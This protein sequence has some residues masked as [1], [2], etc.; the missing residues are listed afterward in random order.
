MALS[1]GFIT[2]IQ[3]LLENGALVNDQDTHGDTALHQAAR[4]DKASCVK[5]L[6]SHPGIDIN[7]RNNEGHTAMMVAK[8]T[9]LGV[10][11]QVVKTCSDFPADS[12]GKVVLCGNSG[13]GKS[14][15]TQR[16]FGLRDEI[17]VEPLTAG[18][19]PHQVD[20]PYS[21]MIIYDLAGHHQYFSSHSA[22][23]E[24]I[25]LTSPAIFLLLQDLRHDPEV[26]TK[27]VYYWSTMIDGVCH[28]CPQQSSVIVMGTHADLLPPGQL[29][30]KFTH[31]RSLAKMA[32]SHQKFVNVLALNAAD[33]YSE[34]M[35]QFIDQLC[36][37]N[38]RVLSMS[39]PISMMCH[40]MLAFLK[41]KIPDPD[42]NAI[43][44]SDL[45]G[46]LKADQDKLIQPFSTEIVPIL[47]TLSEKGLI[48]FIPSEDPLNSWIVLHKESILRKVNGALFADPSLKEYIRVAS[49]TGIV[50]K[51]VIKKIFPEY[52][53]E[54]ITQFMIHFELCQVVELSQIE[55]NMAP[56]GSPSSD[57][58]P[59]LFFPA[60]VSVERPSSATVPNNSFR[61]SMIVKCT[62]QFFT[63]RCLH[64]LLHRLPSEFALPPIQVTPL[65]SDLHRKCALWSRGVMWLSETG[66]T[67]IVKMSETF[68]SLSLAMSSPDRE[69]D[70][71]VNL[72]HSVLAIIKTAC[73][74]FC[75]HLE[76]VELIS[77]PPEA[78]LDHSVDRKVKLSSLKNALLKGHK[79]IADVNGE[80]YVVMEKWMK[81]E[82]CLP[83][84]VGVYPSV[85]PF[86][87]SSLP[88]SDLKVPSSQL[89]SVLITQVVVKLEGTPT[90]LELLSFSDMRVNI[91]EQIG[92][93]YLKFGIFLLGDSNGAI[94]TALENEH[95]KN[96]ERINV[97][98][99]QKWLEGKGVKP[100][101]WSTLLTALQKMN[102]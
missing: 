56:E 57:L 74:E 40:L 18:I 4:E 7:I 80:K 77:C 26:M 99:L 9:S 59:L 37:I 10:F 89:L 35:D 39:P 94:V 95:L 76:V 100:V 52:N 30:R 38:K 50:P 58:G 1:S 85:V 61:W 55:T 63:T 91:A 97:A 32:I 46:Y 19:I 78:S 83:Y 14:T 88:A 102:I 42:V 5:A 69:C 21:N 81:I 17:H 23:L 2:C 27:E 45:I 28:K 65:H 93:N 36:S 49:N 68:Q 44:L 15:L 47:K 33:A 82:P 20:S 67:T 92:V 87:S 34:E 41:Q 29:F 43:F 24:A 48:L 3:L 60:L 90:L 96:A 25:S 86:S 53:V 6:L 101:T 64:V 8:Y 54:M 73:E 79:H 31:L 70:M 12:Y 51:A 62:H 13:A 98:I 22:C 11:K 75:P 66:V 84:L 71:Y 72:A 16:F